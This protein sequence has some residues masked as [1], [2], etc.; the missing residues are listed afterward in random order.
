MAERPKLHLLAVGVSKY[1]D[2]AIESLDYAL[3]DAE[4]VVKAFEQGSGGLYEVAKPV[5][6]ANDEVTRA[7]WTETFSSFVRDLRAEARPDDLLVIF[8]AGHGEVDQRTRTYHFICHDARVSSLLDGSATISW[9]DFELLADIPCRKLAL[10]DTCH[11]GAIQGVQQE[12]KLAIREFQKNV[13]FTVAAAAGDEG[14]LEAE[15]WGHGAFTK[16]LLEGLGGTGD[17][18]ADGIITLDELVAHVSR[19]VPALARSKGYLQH[20]AAAPEELL[21]LVVLPVTRIPKM[22]HLPIRSPKRS[23]SSE[24]LAPGAAGR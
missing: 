7:R 13:I 19:A 14:S 17:A 8:F 22:T 18:S 3:S 5:L 12:H 9:N 4:A 6:L 10:L 24:T 16:T 2:P 20:P 1:A 11:S 21:E 15:E 23:I